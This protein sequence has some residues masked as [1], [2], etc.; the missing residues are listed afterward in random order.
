MRIFA[1]LEDEALAALADEEDV[2]CCEECGES[3][4]EDGTYCEPCMVELSNLARLA[5]PFC[6]QWSWN[7][8]EHLVLIVDG[9]SGWIDVPVHDEDL[10]WLDDDGASPDAWTAGE[11]QAVFGDLAPLAE[12]YE[13]PRCAPHIGDLYE[14]LAGQIAAPV[15][16]QDGINAMAVYAERDREAARSEVEAIVRRLAQGFE[17]LAAHRRSS[18]GA[19]THA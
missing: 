18:S 2:D 12:L 8:C 16:V 17:R 4:T 9:E 11:I 13:T 3:G 14:R 1:S 10:P 15:V 7:D 6:P 5:C 19:D